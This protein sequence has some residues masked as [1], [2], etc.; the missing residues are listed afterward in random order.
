MQ[1]TVYV[2]CC[3]RSKSL[4]GLTLDST[5]ANLPRERCNGRWE[6]HQTIQIS[7]N[8]VS[9]FSGIL[10]RDILSSID[11]VGYYITQIQI[12]FTETTT[13]I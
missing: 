3:S 4:F 11:N 1:R 13:P 12:N 6:S 7:E 5:G 8:D 10:P 9:L 2:F